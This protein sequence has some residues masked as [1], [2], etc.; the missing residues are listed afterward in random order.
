MGSSKGVLALVFVW[1]IGVSVM[2]QSKVTDS[3]ESRLKSSEKEEKVDLLNQLTYEFISVNNAKVLGYNNQALQLSRQLGYIKG[4]GVAHTYRGVY[5]YLSAQFPE[6]H[7]DLHRGLYLSE[8]AGDLVNKGYSLLQLGVCS[9]EEVE[10]DSAL[11]YF[12]KAYEI[13]KDSTNPITLSKIYRNM[14]ALYGQRFQY[15]K[16]ELYLDRA[17]AIR[18]LLSDKMLLIDALALK[19]TNKLT[20]GDLSSA[21]AIL[22]EAESIAVKNPEHEEDINDIRHLKA[23]ILFQKG[24]FNEAVALSDSARNYYLR[25]SLLRKYVTLL[26]DLGQV[27]SERGE[28]E[29]ALNDLYDALRLSKLR[30]FDA[31]AYDIRNRIGWVNF[32]LGDMKQALRLANEG[33]N[34]GNKRQLKIYH[35]DAL[36]LKGVVMTELNDNTQARRCLDSAFQINKRLGDNRRMS[37]ALMNLGFLEAKQQHYTKALELYQRSIQLA[38]TS[39]YA[40]I[41]AWSRWGTGDIYFRQGDFKNATKFLDLSEEYCRLTHSNELLIHNYNT[42]RDLLAAQDSYKESLRFSILATQLKDSIHRTDLARRFVNLEKMQEIEERDRNIKVLQKDKQLAIDKI[43]LQESKLQQQFILLI[44]GFSCIAL[45]GALAFGYYR[46]YSRIKGLNVTITDKNTRIQAQADKL[47]EVNAEL[48]QLYHEVSEQNEKIK[49]QASKL[50]ESNR[51]ISDLNRTLERLVAE[52]TLELRTTNEELVKHNNELLQFSYTVSHNLR[53]PV[54]RLLGLSDLAKAEENLLQAKKWVDL[55]SK[56]ASDLDLVIKDLNKVLDLRNEP[57]QYLEMVDFEKEW[58]QSISLL[59]DSLSGKE[60]IIANFDAFPRI[61]TVR[62]MLQSTFYN[63]LSNAVKFRSPDRNLRVVATSKTV[64]GKVVLEIMDNGLGF[65]VHLHREKMFKLYKRF[66]THVE[67]R[68]I[69]L[70]L[71]KAQI[72][73]LH[74]SIEVE[75]QLGHGS[76]FRVILPLVSEDS[77]TTPSVVMTQTTARQPRV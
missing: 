20:A 6:A 54:A 21:E 45:L 13:L 1:F 73:V 38:E 44:G 2:G 60:E 30:G 15:D 22:A 29:L 32:H 42:R 39:N 50:T 8:Q 43:S 66:H 61:I 31:E 65:D 75:S 48:K 68:G 77:T 56:T 71:I 74:G 28:Y 9:L 62:A 59:D 14:S 58:N 18:R 25:M 10:N 7:K 12:G 52:K 63:L 67:G 69:G 34:I 37:E 53:G 51:D 3:L 40:F 36:M 16:Q 4:E 64:D 70:Y 41:L 27:L 46:F 23:L 49:A 11:H 76:L 33:L 19:A 17:I 24:R 26:T 35:A 5:E 72:E 47:Q 57:D 55:M